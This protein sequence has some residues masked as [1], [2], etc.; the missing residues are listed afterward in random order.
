MD[1]LFSSLR[2]W[3]IEDVEDD[4]ERVDAEGFLDGPPR[5]LRKKG[6]LIFLLPLVVIPVLVSVVP[7]TIVLRRLDDL[8]SCIGG[9]SGERGEGGDVA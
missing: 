8:G 1:A 3:D 2:W 6:P 7:V 5:P 9:A 4:P